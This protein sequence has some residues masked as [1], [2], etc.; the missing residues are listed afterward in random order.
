VRLLI[1]S[2]FEALVLPLEVL[3]SAVVLL[4]AIGSSPSPIL[5]L[6]EAVSAHIGKVLLSDTLFSEFM[7]ELLANRYK[8]LQNDDGF[9]MT[10]VKKYFGKLP[11]ITSNKMFAETL[12]FLSRKLTHILTKLSSKNWTPEFQKEVAT[13]LT[14]LFTVLSILFSS[15]TSKQT[16]VAPFQK[17]LDEITA[18][19]TSSL[20]P[21][22]GSTTTLASVDKKELETLLELVTSVTKH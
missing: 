12:S 19:V 14:L 2:A 17:E 21:P 18:L 20:N 5:P 6:P 10:F 16:Y 13:D 22:A 15:T 4:D 1:F 9:L 11:D 8:E 3:R 7:L